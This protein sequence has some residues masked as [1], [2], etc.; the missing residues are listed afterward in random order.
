LPIEGKH[1]FTACGQ[2]RNRGNGKG[3]GEKKTDEKKNKSD[4]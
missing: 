2:M 3:G 4:N 1:I